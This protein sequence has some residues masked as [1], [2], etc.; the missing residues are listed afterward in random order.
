[1]STLCFFPKV[2]FHRVFLHA[3]A[4]VEIRHY[5]SNVSVTRLIP[6]ETVTNKAEIGSIT[7]D[8]YESVI[9]CPPFHDLHIKIHNKHPQKRENYGIL[10]HVYIHFPIFHHFFNFLK[11]FR[12]FCT[13]FNIFADFRLLTE[14]NF[15]CLVCFIFIA[16]HR[17]LK[18]S[19]IG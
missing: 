1:M 4:H 2:K 10:I 16:I 11:V 18:D 19:L 15:C 7:I 3:R 8:S 12:H 13:F 5:L 9:S 17:L 6:T 14:T